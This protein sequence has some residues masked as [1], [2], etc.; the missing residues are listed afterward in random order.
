M[1]RALFYLPGRDQI[2]ARVLQ[3][4]AHNYSEG[5]P[6]L[7]TALAAG[8]WMDARRLLHSMR[9]ACGAVGAMDLA[10]QSQALEQQLDAMD[11]SNP[12]AAAPSTAA[13]QSAQAILDALDSMV[14]A[15]LALEASTPMAPVPARRSTG[16]SDRLS[17][18]IAEL[19]RLLEV[20]DFSA[21]ALHR[22]IEPLLRQTFSEAACRTLARHLRNHDYEAAQH[23][24]QTMYPASKVAAP[25][26]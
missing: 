19:S 4:F 3:Q 14:K 26:G 17:Q 11:D 23:A 25:A 16:M 22:E 12:G 24:L 1:S 5:L 21:G 15:I 7:M 13:L 20:A 18:A 2:F 10:A 6:G 8:Q 9:G